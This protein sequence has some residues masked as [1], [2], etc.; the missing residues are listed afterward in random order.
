MQSGFT[1]LDIVPRAVCDAKYSYSDNFTGA[2]V[3]G[4]EAN[5]VVG[6][7][8]L[9]RALAKASEIA[10]ERGLGLVLWDAYRPERA[11]KRFIEWAEAP[12]DYRTK[13]RHYPNITKRQMVEEG[14]VSAK[15]GHGRGGSVD[16]TLYSL[17]DGAL[18]DMGG[19][20]DFMDEISHHGAKGISEAAAANRAL[21]RNIM[22]ESGFYAFEGEWWHYTLNDEP[23]PDTYFDFP[24]T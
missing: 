22:E 5:R 9:A 19:I 13:A 14:Y 24:I 11:A 4:Y 17:A 23:Y 16:L 20:F 8:E 1:Y 6:T 18:V 2:P 3:D 21:L 12:E 10:E 15:S 7:V